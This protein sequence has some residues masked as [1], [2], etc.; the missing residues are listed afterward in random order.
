MGFSLNGFFKVVYKGTIMG[1]CNIEAVIIR[2][3]VWGPLYYKC[4]KEPQK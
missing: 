3:G 4:N 2:V 1:L